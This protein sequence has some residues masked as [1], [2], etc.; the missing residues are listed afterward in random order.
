MM[1][2]NTIRN[3]LAR[4]EK[5]METQTAQC[6]MMGWNSPAALFWDKRCVER[7]T[8]RTILGLKPKPFNAADTMAGW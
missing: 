3:W 1:T 7:R 6:R 4:L 5:E 8:L 2:Q